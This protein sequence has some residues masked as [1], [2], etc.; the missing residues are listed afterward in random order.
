MI[1][2]GEDL[3]H[4]NITKRITEKS[5]KNCMIYRKFIAPFTFLPA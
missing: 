4:Y 2:Q 5:S 1:K 3:Y